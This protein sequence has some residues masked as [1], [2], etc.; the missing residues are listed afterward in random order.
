MKIIEHYITEKFLK[1]NPNVLFIFGDNTLGVGKGGAAQLRD[2]ENAIGFITKKY[3]NNE[4]TS[5]YTVSNYYKMFAKELHMLV[6]LIE[7]NL[8]K[9]IYI[10][11][12]GSGLANKYHI[13]ERMIRP[14][15]LDLE[16]QYDNV[17]LVGWE[18]EHFK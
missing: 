17:Y 2:C 8:D 6:K 14:S 5:F 4:D 13:F 18:E 12:L 10:T 16:K 11:P 9:K 7:S 1:N 15:L 3:P